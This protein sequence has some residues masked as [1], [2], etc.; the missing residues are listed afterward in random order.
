MTWS[1]SNALPSWSARN[2]SPAFESR[3]VR[4]QPS[5]VTLVPTGTVPAKICAMRVPVTLALGVLAA[6]DREVHADLHR[7]RLAIDRHDG[8]AVHVPAEA[9]RRELLDLG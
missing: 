4:I 2:D 5:T 1:A 3:R 6:D 9:A 8:L 7:H